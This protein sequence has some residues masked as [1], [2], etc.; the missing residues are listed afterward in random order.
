M[1]I[2]L[3]KY[4]A[5]FSREAG[6]TDPKTQMFTFVKR[7]NQAHEFNKLPHTMGSR[8]FFLGK[9]SST[10]ERV[11]TTEELEWKVDHYNIT[12]IHVVGNTFMVKQS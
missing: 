9:A 1:I 11:Y 2:P 7:I 3:K 5:I 4:Y 10:E 8:L 12:L 6:D